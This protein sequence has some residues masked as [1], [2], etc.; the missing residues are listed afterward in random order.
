MFIVGEV[1]PPPTCVDDER[2]DSYTYLRL[3]VGGGLTKRVSDETQVTDPP[4]TSVDPVQ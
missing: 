3:V 2:W 4:K 1:S